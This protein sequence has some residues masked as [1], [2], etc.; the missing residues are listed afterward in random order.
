MI[1][2]NKFLIFIMFIILLPVCFAL[3]SCGEDP[4]GASNSETVLDTT[5]DTVADTAADTEQAGD[6]TAPDTE[7][8]AKETE[9]SEPANEVRKYKITD[10]KDNLKFHGRTMELSTG[11]ACDAT[12]AGIEFC[13][14]VEGKVNLTVLAT[15]ETSYFTVY[16]DGE[17]KNTRFKAE[18]GSPQS[19]AI[20]YFGTPGVHTIKIVNQ[21][22]A[23]YSLTEYQALEFMGSFCDAPEYTDKYIEII[24][25]SITAG[26]AN[27][28]TGSGGSGSQYQEGTKGW[29]YLAAEKLGV[30]ASIVSCGG[31]GIGKGF[32][33]FIETEFYPKTSYFR[34]ASAEYDFA[35][36]P[37]L[38]IVNLGTNDVSK[39]GTEDEVKNGAR[40]LINMIREKNGE[41][42]PIIF[43][44]GMMNDGNAAN[45]IKIVIDE[46]GGEASG[47]Y[48]LQLNKNGNGG[49]GHPDVE[50][51]ATAA[52]IVA[53]YITEK[54]LLN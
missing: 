19:I 44:Y 3:T 1:S 39:S 54:G 16:V 40:A 27:L 35:R 53:N 4:N 20:A 12:G 37:D 33:D 17:R 28:T 2:K 7:T 22:E 34:D 29:P 36:K 5:K 11:I 8:S 42:V 26:A 21:T 52:D 14:D 18:A 41:N 43:T 46:M 9:T 24:G 10:V 13:I 6:T 15:G 23:Q 51:H 31:I 25:D 45:Y 49:S 47:I 50:G 48:R 38:I 32:K 30:D